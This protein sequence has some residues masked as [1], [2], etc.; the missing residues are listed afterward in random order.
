VRALDG[1][2]IPGNE[3]CVQQAIAALLL[4]GSYATCADEG[5]MFGQLVV[6][7]QNR[8]KA[9]IK[10]WARDRKRYRP[11]AV[12]YARPRQWSDGDKDMV[13]EAV[14]ELSSDDKRVLTEVVRPRPVEQTR[15][16]RIDAKWVLFEEAVPLDAQAV[17]VGEATRKEMI[18]RFNPGMRHLRT[19]IFDNKMLEHQRR[20]EKRLADHRLAPSV[21]R[22]KSPYDGR[23]IPDYSAHRK[24]I[25][26]WVDDA[27]AEF[28]KARQQS[29]DQVSSASVPTPPGHVWIG[30]QFLGDPQPNGSAYSPFQRRASDRS[31]TPRES[32]LLSETDDNLARALL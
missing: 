24:F 28:K 7:V 12:E 5:E 9:M 16:L 19:T 32:S 6:T 20:L 31:V 4:R 18:D 21:K 27:V 15:D 22:E 8:A 25:R 3:D 1:G 2:K 26:R 29:H 11:L 14:H 30:R 23:M 17:L 10:R 13:G